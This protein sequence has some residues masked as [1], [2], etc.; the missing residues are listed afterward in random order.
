ML[1]HMLG[2]GGECGEALGRYGE[3][4]G[5]SWCCTSQVRGG[6]VTTGQAWRSA[7]RLGGTSYA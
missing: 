5:V 1:S 2:S 4:V 6:V 7:R 3:V